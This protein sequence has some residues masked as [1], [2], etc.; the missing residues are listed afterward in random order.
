MILVF[1]VSAEAV[2]ARCLSAMQEE[3]I[4]ASKQLSGPSTTKYSGDKK[5]FINDIKYVSYLVSNKVTEKNH[6]EYRLMLE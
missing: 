5:E 1:F 6:A 4:D 2:F 3:R